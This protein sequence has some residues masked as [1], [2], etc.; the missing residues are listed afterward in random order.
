MIEVHSI[1]ALIGGHP[2]FAEAGQ[3]I[4]ALLASCAGNVVFRDGDL[5]LKEGDPANRFLLIRSGRVRLETSVPGRGSVIVETL[6]SGEA[7]GL[8]WL[9]PPY[10]TDFDTRAIGTVRAVSFDAGCLRAK[11]E[12]DPRI[13]YTFYKLLMP[14]LVARLRT[15]RIQAL[16]LYAG[17]SEPRPA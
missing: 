7:L 12:G 5:I 3:E 6:K 1:G 8:S 14:T 2:L 10:V 9:V 15:A 16:D 17:V 11:C 4:A 13:G